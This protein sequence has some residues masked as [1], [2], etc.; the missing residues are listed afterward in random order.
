M[1][2]VVSLLAPSDTRCE[3]MTRGRS[4]PAVRWPQ[5]TCSLR[6]A[7]GPGGDHRDSD[8]VATTPTDVRV[9]F[10]TQAAGTVDGHRDFGFTPLFSIGNRVFRDDGAGGGVASNG[11]LDGAEA[12]IDGVA[13]RL[14][15]STG[16]APL[17]S[18]TTASGGYY[19]F[20]GLTPGAYYVT[21]DSGNFA[22]GKPLAG[23][24]SSPVSPADPDGNIDGDDDGIGTVV[25]P[26]A[27]VRSANITLGP[28][29]I[30]P[31]GEVDRGSQGQTVEAP[32]G[33]SNL[34]LD[35]GFVPPELYE[36][37][38]T[39]FA[40]DDDNGSLGAVES[41]LVGVSVELYQGANVVART[42]TG[43][44]GFYHFT[45]LYAG[46]YVVQMS[47]PSFYRSS[48]DP[49]SGADEDTSPTDGDD[50]GIGGSTLARTAP[51]TLGPGQ[52]EPGGR[53][54]LQVDLG[55]VPQL[56]IGGS[57]FHDRNQN[58]QRDLAEIYFG[59]AQVRLLR[60]GTQ[61]VLSVGQTN[62]QGHYLFAGLAP[63]DYMVEISGPADTRSTTDLASTTRPSIDDDDNG[64]GIDR[65]A[66]TAPFT[67]RKGFG[68]VSEP[69]L[70]GLI[71][72]S[73]D[74]NDDLTVDFGLV[75]LA[76]L[77]VKALV[78]VTRPGAKVNIVVTVRNTEQSRVG[79]DLVRTCLKLPRRLVQVRVSKGGRFA[80][81]EACW[82]ATLMEVRNGRKYYVAATVSPTTP[83]GSRM[84]MKL[85]A[86]GRNAPLVVARPVLIVR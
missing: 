46:D 79:A 50:N 62:S 15:R 37:G 1:A 64:I 60:A 8:A 51:V 29:V 32:D 49:A 80:A 75:R 72:P 19:R 40:D 85:W 41:G 43:T 31:V 2:S 67:V 6:A 61:A 35:F 58:G 4:R 82:R 65:V 76:P 25:A 73:T 23:H 59:F 18:M 84:T 28:E 38:G 7:A 22:K 74:T 16:G 24:A 56:A 54:N 14:F 3:S 11:V 53:V 78:P 57:V 27:P 52:V 10:D 68:A 34:T 20:D 70:P 12:G 45:D 44:A 77:A 17:K 55:F 13:V 42:T 39:A 66:I 36:I 30:E 9:A 86:K 33:R 71:D 48:D 47:A 5:P 63:G 69:R 83:R 21:V 26:G 81:G